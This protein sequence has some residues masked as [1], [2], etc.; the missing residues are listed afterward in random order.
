MHAGAPNLCMH[1]TTPLLGHRD[2]RPPR[3]AHMRPPPPP[4]S[5]F[6]LACCSQCYPGGL[7]RS[8]CCHQG[9][10]TECYLQAGPAPPPPPA[11]PG[12]PCSSVCV[13]FSESSCVVPTQASLPPTPP[14]SPPPSLSP[15]P[16]TAQPPHRPLSHPPSPFL[17]PTHPPTHPPTPFRAPQVVTP[18]SGGGGGASCPFCKR[19]N[20]SAEYLGPLSA[21]EQQRAQEEEQKVIKL[22]IDQQ[23]RQER[24][25]RDRLASRGVQIDG[26]PAR[27]EHVTTLAAAEAAPLGHVSRMPAASDTVRAGAGEPGSP[28]A[29]SSGG[30]ELHSPRTT[31]ASP[32]RSPDLPPSSP[33]ASGPLPV[34]VGIA[35]AAASPDALASHSTS[36]AATAASPVLG[37]HQQSGRQASPPRLVAPIAQ[38]Q[39]SHAH[40]SP[41]PRCPPRCP[42][43]CPARCPHVPERRNEGRPSPPS[44]A[45]AAPHPRPPPG[46]VAARRRRRGRDGRPLA[47]GAAGAARAGE[48]GLSRRLARLACRLLGHLRHAAGPRP[49][50][51]TVRRPPPP[52]PP[53]SNAVPPTL[54]SE[55]GP[56]SAHAPPR[57]CACARPRCSLQHVRLQALRDGARGDGA[58]TY[59]MHMPCAGPSRWSSRR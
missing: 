16:T 55:P 7:N 33:H 42:A 6:P 23:V 25:Y 30:G 9:V 31:A 8:I 51:G 39:P 58:H 44:T 48:P 52:T 54:R 49:Q 38:V 28:T 57:T 36:L 41:P 17:N 15:S 40:G 11:R 21:F 3:H 45:P 14:P 35:A 2:S 4:P 13:R 19:A 10:C 22:Q 12:P 20:Y 47:A 59:T 56:A 24:A 34:A 27:L 32:H 43:R 46:L 37:A 26:A 18:R 50:H 29:S 53:P 5:T 1:S